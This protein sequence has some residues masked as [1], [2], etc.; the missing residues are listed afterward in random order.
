MIAGGLNMAESAK[1]SSAEEQV[2]REMRAQLAAVTGGIAPDDYAQAWWD[3]YLNL[4]QAPQ[5]Q[6]D[7]AQSA[8]NALNDNFAF[9]LR[10]A[11]GQPLA[12][13]ADDKRFGTEAWNQ[14]PFNVIARGYLNWAQV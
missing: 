7:I 3:W 8:F 14:W 12:P 10:A 4:A 13:A 2:S 9:A 1:G 11:T 5:K 6:T